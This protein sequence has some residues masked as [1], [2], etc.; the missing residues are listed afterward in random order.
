MAN[1]ESAVDI[2]KFM[3]VFG[4]LIGVIREQ[5]DK[6]DQLNVKSDRL[7]KVAA[8]AL[9][10]ANKRPPPQV[11]QNIV[12]N[13]GDSSAQPQPAQQSLAYLD[14]KLSALEDKL[15]GTLLEL[16]GLGEDNS[17]L[18][19]DESVPDF[20]AVGAFTAGPPH[21]PSLTGMSK[22]F[23][24][25][26]PA[27]MEGEAEDNDYGHYESKPGSAVSSAF[28]SKR[29]SIKDDSADEQATDETAAEDVEEEKQSA[30]ET[31]S[32][33]S[34]QVPEPAVVTEAQQ[35]S[36][37]APAIDPS[38]APT[39]APEVPT[40]PSAV[41]IARAPSPAR[42]ISPSAAAVEDARISAVPARAPHVAKGITKAPSAAPISDR[43]STMRESFTTRLAEIENS[44]FPGGGIVAPKSAAITKALWTASVAAE[45][46]ED[47]AKT[48]PHLHRRIIPHFQKYHIDA[49]LPH[50]RLV[51]LAEYRDVRSRDHRDKMDANNFNF[52]TAKKR[53]KLCRLLK[54]KGRFIQISRNMLE[55]NATRCAN[56]LSLV[57]FCGWFDVASR[58]LIR[59]LLISA[60]LY[61]LFF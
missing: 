43:P 28:A 56:A 39:P 57:V 12:T 15:N 45:S 52:L 37:V 44:A 51:A 2:G 23:I 59:N 4:T 7:E 60:L 5:Q 21:A 19:R 16:H 40:E 8:A 6:I 41:P 61:C 35:P 47:H 32:G 25:I 11:I 33:E 27:L 48:H 18:D 10:A 3:K 54:Q 20:L 46:T 26:S 55:G 58:I 36:E 30:E 1:L 17:M 29:S 31:E 42:T 13:S 24:P 53:H 34:N 49:K 22:K 14:E 50:E 9:E 38:P